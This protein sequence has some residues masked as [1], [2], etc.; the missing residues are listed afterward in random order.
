MTATQKYE[1][2]APIWRV[3]R[4]EKMTAAEVETQVKHVALAVKQGTQVRTL[5]R[6]LARILKMRCVST[7]ECACHAAGV[8]WDAHSLAMVLYAGS[9]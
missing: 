1:F 5:Q 9:L 6:R 7:H 8:T 2:F 3:M 4:N